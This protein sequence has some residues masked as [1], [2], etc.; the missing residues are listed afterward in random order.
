MLGLELVKIVLFTLPYVMSSP[1]TGFEPQASALLEKTDIIASTPHALVD[2]V[3]TFSSEEN[4]A[5]AGPSVISLMQSQ[6]QSEASQGWELRCLPR[7]WKGVQEIDSG[8]QKPWE[9]LTKVPFPEINVPNPVPNGARPL[10]PEVFLSVYANQEVDTVPPLSDISSSLLRDALVDTINLLHFNRVATAKYLI[11][12]DCYF[13]PDTFVK[14]ATPF[15][16]MRD[17]AGESQAWKP[18][19]VAVDAV[20]SQLYQLP[21][22]E[23]KLIYYHSVLTEC[24]KIAPAAIAPS[25]GRAIRFL[26]NNLDTMDLELSSR[27]LDWFAHHLSNFGFTWKWS[28][29]YVVTVR[30]A[31]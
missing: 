11:D 12:V 23:H 1:A 4:T 15:D 25:L 24:C 2:L 14:R 31:N 30:I 16:R 29:W 18:E 6:L 22:P 26:Y 5:A 3:N 28:E 19:D 21:T 20:F 27:F 9:V 17:L 10:F 8:E 7:P 13:T